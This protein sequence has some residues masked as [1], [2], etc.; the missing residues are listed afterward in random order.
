MS[1][2]EQVE[3]VEK[4][5]IVKSPGRVAAG[6]K[7]AEM[8]KKNKAKKVDD[9]ST[10]DINPGYIIGGIG[11]AIAAGS[12]YLQWRSTPAAPVIIPERSKIPV[13]TERSKIPDMD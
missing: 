7:L 4:I 8:N 5:T 9:S 2:T 3:Q 6:K 10:W 13:S 11:I 12:L 1:D